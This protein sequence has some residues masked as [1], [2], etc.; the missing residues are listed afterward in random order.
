MTERNLT[1]RCATAV[2][3]GATVL[4]LSACGPEAAQRDESSGEITASAD[5]DVFTLE[6]GDCLDMEAAAATEVETLPTVP[7][8]DPHD[9]EVYAETDLTGEEI[10]ADLD[11]Q[12][13]T[14]CYDAFEPF[15]GMAYEESTLDFSYLA[16]TAGSWDQG[17]RSVQC[18]LQSPEPVTGTLEGAAV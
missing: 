15:I 17:D 9:S 8:G 10:P 12:A 7:C 16:P 1:A 6:V 4:L 11:D 2:L 3:A 13:G 14:F 18:V 5:A